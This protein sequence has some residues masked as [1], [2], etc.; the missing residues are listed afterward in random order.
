MYIYISK[1][2]WKSLLLLFSLKCATVKGMSATK[3]R[4]FSRTPRG[5]FLVAELGQC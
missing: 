2:S 1:S 5:D 4:S 3:T